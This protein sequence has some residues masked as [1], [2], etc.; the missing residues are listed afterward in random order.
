MASDNP[1]PTGVRNVSEE[2]SFSI[3][4][5]GIKVATGIGPYDDIRREAAHYAAV[6][7]KDGPVKVR[8]R[9][10]RETHNL[11]GQTHK[12]TRNPGDRNVSSTIPTPAANIPSGEPEAL[13][14]CP[15]CQ[16]APEPDEDG[17]SHPSN[18]CFLG[19]LYIPMW[20][21]TAWNTRPAEDRK[22]DDVYCTDCG[23]LITLKSHKC[24]CFRDLGFQRDA[25]RAQM[26]RL[27]GDVQKVIEGDYPQATRTTPCKH[28]MSSWDTCGN[29][30]EEALAA[31]LR[32][33]RGEG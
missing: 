6:Y 11:A 28:G 19:G 27:M 20:A 24:D 18:D 25:L 21:I 30:I 33:A 32:V 31:A 17:Y 4:Q 26:G 23:S 2:G 14:A 5:D 16:A 3:Y 22:A 7:G 15:L 12:K 10:L 13:K 1:T 29:C 9:K 8:V